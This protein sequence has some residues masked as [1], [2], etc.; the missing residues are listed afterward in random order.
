LDAADKVALNAVAARIKALGS[1]TVTVRGFAQKTT[2]SKL[3]AKL[4]RDRANAVVAYLRAK[5]P[6]VSIKVLPPV[7]ATNT[8]AAA[9][10]ALITVTAPKG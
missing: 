4:S 8:S 7:K 1:A 10:R 3:D 9:R 5:A 2:F 6:G